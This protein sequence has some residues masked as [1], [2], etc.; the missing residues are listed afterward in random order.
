MME[1]SL[2]LW[3]TWYQCS[4]ILSVR[5]YFLI[6]RANLVCFDFSLLPLV[7]SLGTTKKGSLYLP[8]R[9]L[10]TLMSSPPEPSL[11]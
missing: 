8:F 7:L 1:T 11:S 3:A 4:V 2:H 9:Y 6:S 5:K 10:Y